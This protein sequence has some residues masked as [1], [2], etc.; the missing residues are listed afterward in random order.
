MVDK[1][2]KTLRSIR[3]KLYMLKHKNEG[4]NE[5]TGN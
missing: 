5:N 3:S 1:G 2:F 4:Q